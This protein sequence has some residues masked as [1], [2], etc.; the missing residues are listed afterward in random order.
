MH[1]EHRLH[2]LKFLLIFYHSIAHRAGVT[3]GTTSLA[4]GSMFGAPSISPIGGLST[5]FRTGSAHALESGAIV[6]NFTALH[7][8]I[9]REPTFAGVFGLSFPFP[10]VSSQIMT[11]RKLLLE[12]NPTHSD[13]EGKSWFTKASRVKFATDFFW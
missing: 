12:E 8:S 11:L 13:E 4:L 9:G 6:K 3:Y 1:C 7:V 5:T 2:R 10:S